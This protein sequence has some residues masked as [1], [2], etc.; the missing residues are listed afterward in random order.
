VAAAAD[1]VVLGG[2]QAGK[3]VVARNAAARAAAGLALER[4]QDDRLVMALGE[5]RGDD[6]DDPRVPA[7][8]RDHKRRV[9]GVVGLL[10][11]ERLLRPTQDLLLGIAALAVAAVELG[12]DLARPLL[13]CG[14]HQLDA[15]I[16]AVEPPGGVDPRAQPEREVA[17]VEPL[18][19]DLGDIEQRP[20]PGAAGLA[21]DL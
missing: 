6:A 10:L 4:D 9:A 2:A 19:L 17:L 15:G 8:S 21:Q 1:Q 13:V 5:P 11:A 20:H 7:L 18:R 16:G 12:G 3:Q 14:Q